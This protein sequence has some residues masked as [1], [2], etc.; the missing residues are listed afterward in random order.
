VLVVIVLHRESAAAEFLIKADAV[1]RTERALAVSLID[2]VFECPCSW[3]E[4]ICVVPFSV[5]AAEWVWRACE[6]FVMAKWEGSGV[7]NAEFAIGLG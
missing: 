2:F 1:V 4:T 5:A 7:W 3:V 6:E